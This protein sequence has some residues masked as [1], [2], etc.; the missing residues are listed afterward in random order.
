[1]H[2]NMVIIIIYIPMGQKMHQDYILMKMEY[3]QQHSK[4]LGRRLWHLHIIPELKLDI[5][6]TREM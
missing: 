1:M 6:T 3:F 5:W 2:Q 4:V